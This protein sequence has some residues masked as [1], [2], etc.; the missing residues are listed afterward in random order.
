MQRDQVPAG[1]PYAR[2]IVKYALIALYGLANVLFGSPSLGTISGAFFE[3]L[4]PMLLVIACLVAIVG[5]IRSRNYNH[6]G[7]EISST[8]AII[9]LLAAYSITIITRCLLEGTYTRMPVAILPIIVMVAPFGRL[10][11]IARSA[12]NR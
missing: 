8:L 1:P 12:G 6:Q 7:L 5:V 4:W 11:D 10:L 9:G 3:A 2:L